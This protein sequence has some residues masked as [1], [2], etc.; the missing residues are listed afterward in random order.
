M[1]AEQRI[2]ERIWL[3]A[4]GTLAQILLRMTS[5]TLKTLGALGLIK[6]SRLVLLLVMLAVPK[7]RK[8]LFKSR[9]QIRKLI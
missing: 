4:F 2:T 8:S 6:N 1:T 7:K 3:R 9:A 5:D